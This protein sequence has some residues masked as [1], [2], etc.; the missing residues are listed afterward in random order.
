MTDRPTALATTG[1]GEGPCGPT[2]TAASTEDP[3]QFVIAG[4]GREEFA[5]DVLSVQEIIRLVELTRLPKAPPFVEGVINLRGRIIPVLNLRRRFGL[6]ETTVT[7]RQRI[8]VVMVRQRMVGLLVDEVAE[9]LRIGL[10]AI[11]PPPSIMGSSTGAEFTR[12]VGRL[13]DRLI[14]VL[15]LERLLL[16]AEQ[17][18]T[19]A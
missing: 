4:I 3:L 13:D 5:I 18:A 7:D 15:D 9:V 17:A 2:H 8:V 14:V 19:A 12:G 16:P 1:V 10:S 6:S 11:E